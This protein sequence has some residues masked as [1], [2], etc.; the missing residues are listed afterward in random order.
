MRLWNNSIKYRLARLMLVTCLIALS[1]CSEKRKSDLMPRT[2][3]TDPRRAVSPPDSSAAAGSSASRPGRRGSRGLADASKQPQ[4]ATL[5]KSSSQAPGPS[6]QDPISDAQAKEFVT[7]FD[8]AIS[9]G[10]TA[11]LGGMIDYEA[12]IR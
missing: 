11:A 8:K 1:G 2:V 12:M 7:R 6:N 4:T 9:A 10:D 3:G 5:A